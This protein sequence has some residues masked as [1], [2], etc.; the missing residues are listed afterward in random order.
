MHLQLCGEDHSFIFELGFKGCC[1][2]EI[3]IIVPI[4]CLQMLFAIEVAHALSL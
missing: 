3:C 2:R 1:R 4:I